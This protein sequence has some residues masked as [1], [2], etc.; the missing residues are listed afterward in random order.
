MVVNVFTVG[1]MVV[2]RATV[3][4]SNVAG[5]KSAGPVLHFQRSPPRI[6]DPLSVGD[7]SW[8]ADLPSR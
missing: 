5:A 2:S 8:V 1:W 7:R 6:D 4:A 3:A